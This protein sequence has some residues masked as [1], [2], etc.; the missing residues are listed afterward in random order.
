MELTGKR[1][2]LTG[3][4]GGLGQRVAAELL[5]QGAGVTGFPERF[6]VRLNAVMPRLVD[7]A[8]ASGDRKAMRLF[9][10]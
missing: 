2:I 4:S 9:A 5:R 8:V 7:A 10:V 6:F 3:G 1:I